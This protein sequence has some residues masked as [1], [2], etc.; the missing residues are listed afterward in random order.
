MA[1]NK[2]PNGRAEPDVDGAHSGGNGG[3]PVD[4]RA[5]AE[6]FAATSGPA[7][8][9][10]V[11]ELAAACVRFVR[12]A[13]QVEPDFTRDTLPL[14]DHY[15]AQSRQAVRER[16]ETL[17]LIAQAAGAY[18]G[19]VVRRTYPCWW[20]LD[21]AE[22]VEWRLEFRDVYLAFHPVEMAYAA[23]TQLGPAAEPAMGAE[24]S[25]PA[26]PSHPTED[27]AQL[28]GPP[29]GDDPSDGADEPVLV[30][31][32]EDR[33][34]VA[35]RLDEIPPVA[36]QDYYALSTRLEVIDVA[37][38]AIRSVLL[39]S[40]ERQRVHRPGDYDPQSH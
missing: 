28:Y 12:T 1:S 39:A 38:A 22:P 8:P 29:A 6:A 24:A 25:G 17:P 15:L 3:D 18:F 31:A 14:V 36:E 2:P 40:P 27:E 34:A 9:Q 26:A 20:R 19:E 37:V 4:P 5:A 23:L 21:R 13:V 33:Q 35:D 7:P 30:L 16:P 32:D 11:L 10:E